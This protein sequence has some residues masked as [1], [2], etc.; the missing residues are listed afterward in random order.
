[1]PTIC[2]DDPPMNEVIADGENGPSWCRRTPTVSALRHPREAPGYPGDERGDRAAGRSRRARR[3]AR[4][5]TVRSRE[6]FRWR[7]EDTVAALGELLGADG[8]PEWHARRRYRRCGDAGRDRGGPRCPGAFRADGAR[9]RARLRAGGDSRRRTQRRANATR[10]PVAAGRSS[11]PAGASCSA[12]AGYNDSRTAPPRSSR[13]GA[14]RRRSRALPAL[15][16]RRRRPSSSPCGDGNAVMRS[17]PRPSRAPPPTGPWS[18]R[19]LQYEDPQLGHRSPP[20]AAPPT[21]MWRR[22]PPASPIARRSSASRTPPAAPPAEISLN[23]TGRPPGS[24]PFTETTGMADMH[25]HV[26][27]YE[28]LGGRACGKPW[29][30]YGSRLRARRLPRPL[31]QQ[32]RDPREPL[33]RQPGPHPDPVGWPTFR[34]W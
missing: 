7:W 11:P 17:S 22:A 21:A 18:T 12:A 25:N 6:C 29:D 31:P 1:M 23:A 19:A 16:P 2:N 15:Q 4:A 34:S 20:S 28:F 33:L 27:A 24:S 32:R 10:W 3:A 14:R 30:A 8:A 9:R 26:S 5:G 13:S